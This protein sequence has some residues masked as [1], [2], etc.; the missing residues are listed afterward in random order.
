MLD[1]NV[2]LNQVI[3]NNVKQTNY[4][5]NESTR[6]QTTLTLIKDSIIYVS[7]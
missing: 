4:S 6:Y 2:T 1:S 7:V 3:E 5:M